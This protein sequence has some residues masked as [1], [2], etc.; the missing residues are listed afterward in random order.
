MHGNSLESFLVAIISVNA[1]EL[2][3]WEAA[4]GSP[5]GNVLQLPGNATIHTSSAA[6]L[7]KELTA[8]G[9]REGLHS[10]EQAKSLAFT[11]EL[12]AV[13]N[14]L[15]T[16][17]FKLRRNDLRK[18]CVQCALNRAWPC[19][20]LLTNVHVPLPPCSFTA[21]IT[22][23]Y[24]HQPGALL[25]AGEIGLSSGDVEDSGGEFKKLQGAAALTPASGIET[26]N[27]VAAGETP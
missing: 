7:L 8:L 20:P 1:A 18:W 2:A 14:G 24:K 22:E 21:T 3:R 27:A 23:L 9:K 25:T 10:F 11:S 13:D 26:R 17:T 6:R 16:P 12:F 19:L 15:L 5:S 4:V